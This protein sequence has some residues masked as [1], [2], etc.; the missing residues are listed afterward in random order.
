MEDVQYCEGC[1]VLWRVFSRVFS[2]VE[3]VHYCRG[4]PFKA[5][6]DNISISEGIRVFITV[7]GYHLVL[8][9]RCSVSAGKPNILSLHPSS[10][11]VESGEKIWEILK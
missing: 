6:G 5:V 2:T 9:G 11:F 7:G 8:F 4:I 1:S 3:D 10:F